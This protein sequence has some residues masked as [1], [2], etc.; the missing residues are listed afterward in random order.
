MNRIEAQRG[1]VFS[2]YETSTVIENDEQA[3][4]LYDKWGS[5][6]FDD[7]YEVDK[8]LV[9]FEVVMNYDDPIYEYIL[10]EFKV[11]IYMASLFQIIEDMMKLY[12]KIDDA[13]IRV[14]YQQYHVE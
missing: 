8:L 4:A 11:D 14:Y 9:K 6:V 13:V 3:K 7:S 12:L 5:R 1:F 10:F 2:K